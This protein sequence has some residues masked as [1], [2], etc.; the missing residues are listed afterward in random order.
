MSNINNGK[1]PGAMRC[2]QLMNL[3]HMLPNIMQHCI[4]VCKVAL[5]ISKDL[6]KN[7]EKLNLDMIRAAAL[8]HDI[9]KTMSLKTGENHAET[10]SQ[11]LIRAGYGDIAEIVA[12]H[13]NPGTSGK[14]ITEAKIV[15]Y[16]DKR[17]L[18]D[19]V[20]SLDDRFAYLM[21][22]YGKNETA[23]F[24]INNTKKLALEIETRIFAKLGSGQNSI[25]NTTVNEDIFF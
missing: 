14:P 1:I 10:G 22:R 20:V 13:I 21:E 11:L 19:K 17:V 16:A 15:S 23:V 25:T 24:R 12:K 2:F 18:H 9:T 3:H 7:A 6:N 4:M 5:T 8:L